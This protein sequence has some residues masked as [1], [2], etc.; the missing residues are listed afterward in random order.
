MAQLS[1]DE[2][3]LSY[4]SDWEPTYQ[5]D[6][7]V[8]QDGESGWRKTPG[9]FG[10]WHNP[11]TFQYAMRPLGFSPGPFP[12]EMVPRI[13]KRDSS[14][15]FPPAPV[16]TAHWRH[17]AMPPVSTGTS[18]ASSSWQSSAARAPERPPV[19]KHGAIA[20]RPP[21]KRISETGVQRSAGRR[22]SLLS[23]EVWPDDVTSIEQEE[24]SNAILP[25]S[26]VSTSAATSDYALSNTSSPHLK[27]RGT[28]GSEEWGRPPAVPRG[29]YGKM[30]T[31]SESSDGSGGHMTNSWE[32]ASPGDRARH[33]SQRSSVFGAVNPIQDSAEI[34]PPQSPF[35]NQSETDGSVNS[36]DDRMA[37][38]NQILL[39]NEEYDLMPQWL[40]P[41]EHTSNA[42]GRYSFAGVLS[43]ELG[44]IP[45]SNDSKEARST[46][47]K[48][49]LHQNTTQDA[50]EIPTDD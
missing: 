43:Q 39:P 23:R 14:Q 25:D 5:F 8:P 26:P 42:G 22:S 44:I 33:G 49:K 38:A 30:R 45:G 28:G 40:T 9:R 31:G 20:K 7:N 15:Q 18:S 46:I 24:D 10:F 36:S 37:A 13:M 6:E 16:S 2:H 35:A 32:C 12:E 21:Q 34:S 29:A 1:D 4:I 3:W 27:R 48:S 17:P 11:T 47:C 50:F 19:V 41:E